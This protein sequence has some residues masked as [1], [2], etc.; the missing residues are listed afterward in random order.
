MSSY[1]LFL[2]SLPTPERPVTNVDRGTGNS[3]EKDT[4]AA[5][6]SHQE[7]G[8]VGQGAALQHVESSDVKNADALMED[9]RAGKGEEVSTVCKR[10][11]VLIVG[12][13]RL[14]NK[15]RIFRAHSL[16]IASR[17]PSM[18]KSKESAAY[19][20]KQCPHPDCHLSH[21]TL[22]EEQVSDRPVSLFG[23]I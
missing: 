6:P 18:G 3:G 23:T 7:D 2:I 20:V 22:S 15:S 12:T 13:R 8:G 4:G 9:Q 14:T 11:K 5:S 17:I 1:V 19:Q 16:A 10:Q 21:K